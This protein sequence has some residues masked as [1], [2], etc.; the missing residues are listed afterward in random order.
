MDELAIKYK[1][2]VCSSCEMMVKDDKEYYYG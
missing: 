2:D 1:L